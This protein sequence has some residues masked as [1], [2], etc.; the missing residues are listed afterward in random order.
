MVGAWEEACGKLDQYGMQ[1]TRAFSNLCN[2]GVP[3][4][5]LGAQAAATCKT[6]TVHG[7][8]GDVAVKSS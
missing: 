2:A 8:R 5:A 1:H 7:N 3:P 6:G 4:A